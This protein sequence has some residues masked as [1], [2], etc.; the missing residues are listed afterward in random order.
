MDRRASEIASPETADELSSFLISIAESQVAQARALDALRTLVRP[1]AEDLPPTLVPLRTLDAVLA[2]VDD[3][4]RAHAATTRSLAAHVAAAERDPASGSPGPLP[5]AGLLRRLHVEHETLHGLLDY[6][7]RVSAHFVAPADAS[8]AQRLL[9]AA[10]AAWDRA[11]RAVL[12]SETDVL[13]P[14]VLALDPALGARARPVSLK[15]HCREVVSSDRRRSERSVFCPAERRSVD[16][17][18]C[19]TC[20]LVHRVGPDA[21]V[22]TPHPEPASQPV[23]RG[24]LGDDAAVGEA[25]GDYSVSVSSEV[26]A[27]EVPL[28]LGASS[29]TAVLV[30]DDADHL[31]GILDAQAASPP[32]GGKATGEAG[33]EGPAIVESATLAD[34]V[35]CMVRTHRRFLPVIGADRRVVGVIRDLDALRWVSRHRG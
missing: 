33:L 13:V 2:C 11:Q 10:L 31:I 35:A 27:S 30:V 18:W 17:G 28:L 1:S 5:L 16:V 26:L 34:A 6:A 21:V 7:T 23:S 19:R 12:R 22:C 3:A 8:E 29:S 15:V 14:R 4:T 9:Y 24:R 32:A 20:P 25:M